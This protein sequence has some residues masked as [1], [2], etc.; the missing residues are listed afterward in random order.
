[1]ER[2]NKIKNRTKSKRLIFSLFFIAVA[3]FSFVME[4]IFYGDIDPDGVLQESFFLPLG[5]VS[6][7]LGFIGL[8]ITLIWHLINKVRFK[9]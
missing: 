7:L 3:V 6:F 4:N 8:T 9:N 1:M 2:V 5:F